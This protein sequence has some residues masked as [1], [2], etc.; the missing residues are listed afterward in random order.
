[1]QF[2]LDIHSGELLKRLTYKFRRFLLHL[3]RSTPSSPIYNPLRKKIIS[4]LKGKKFDAYIVS[5]P[6]SGK[7]WLIAI[8]GFVITKHFQ[9]QDDSQ[10]N[11]IRNLYRLSCNYENIPNIKFLHEDKILQKKHSELNTDKSNF[12]KIPTLL[13]VR[14]P[15]DIL[16]SSYYHKTRNEAINGIAPKMT[17]TDYIHAP[18]DYFRTLTRFYNLWIENQSDLSHFLFVKYED[19]IQYPLN[20]LE[21]ILPFLGFPEIKKDILE[22]A[23]QAA[24][25]SNMKRM[26]RNQEIRARNPGHIK[27]ENSFYFRKAV[28]GGYRDE[29]CESDIKY[30]NNRISELSEIYG[31]V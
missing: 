7:N 12:R 2:L 8:L 22:F 3:A 4:R 6:R 27:D 21:K 29:L 15:R 26:E 24:S 28:V 18:Q 17:L 16:V 13:L 1:M 19:L 30:L 5:V 25:F 20:T 23:I 14:D 9:I 31:Y 10:K 11:L